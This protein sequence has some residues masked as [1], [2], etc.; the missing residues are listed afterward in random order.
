LLFNIFIT[1]SVSAGF[2]SSAIDF[3]NVPA[4]A[5]DVAAAAQATAAF[6]E[7]VGQTFAVMGLT[8]AQIS[9]GLFLLRIVVRTKCKVVV[10][11]ATATLSLVTVAT[12]IAFWVQCIPVQAIYDPR[13]QGYCRVP[14]HIFAILH[15]CKFL[16]PRP[17]CRSSL[18]ITI[19]LTA[20]SALVDFFFACA[21]ARVVFRL[22]MRLHEKLRI[23][24]CISPSIL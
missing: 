4:A 9:L 7:V 24:A 20:W 23:V 21:T 10:S 2:G 14:I 22:N 15:G 1:I 13:V 5:D 11:T 6:W 12:I 19:N 3:G 16:S 18:T 8:M 17:L